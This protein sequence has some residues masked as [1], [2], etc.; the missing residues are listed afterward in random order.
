MCG[1]SHDPI[2]AVQ[3]RLASAQHNDTISDAT[4]RFVQ[5]LLRK[6]VEARII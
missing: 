3:Q 4:A 6:V 2:A 1:Q 5:R